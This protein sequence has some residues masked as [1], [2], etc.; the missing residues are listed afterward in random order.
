MLKGVQ[1]K[2][3]LPPPPTNLGLP[4]FQIFET[5]TKMRS[6]PPPPPPPRLFSSWLSRSE[7]FRRDFQILK[8]LLENIL[9]TPLI[10]LIPVVTSKYTAP[11]ELVNVFDFDFRFLCDALYSASQKKI[12]TESY[13]CFIIT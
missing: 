3:T 7:N 11:S 2:M 4:N 9:R 13:R 8:P 5:K 10:T 1:K 6:S 12:E